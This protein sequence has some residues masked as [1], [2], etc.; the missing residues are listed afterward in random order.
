MRR[1]G[2]RQGR[3]GQVACVREERGDDTNICAA[4]THQ[5]LTP[6]SIFN[7]IRLVQK[8]SNFSVLLVTVLVTRTECRPRNPIMRQ[9][10]MVT[11]SPRFVSLYPSPSTPLL[12]FLSFSSSSLSLSS[13]THHTAGIPTR[14]DRDEGLAWRKQA[15][16]HHHQPQPSTLLP[17]WI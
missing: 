1:V 6:N 14:E 17:L 11:R 9:R 5:L 15:R 4:Y 8:I 10:R 16:P 3:G 2:E 12:L 7:L 13:N